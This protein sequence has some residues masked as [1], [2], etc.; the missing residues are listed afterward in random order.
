MIIIVTGD[1]A[2]GKTTF[3]ADLTEKLQDMGFRV[4]GFYSRGIWKNRIRDHYNLF[5]IKHKEE[6]LLCDRNVSDEKDRVGEYYFRKETID[7]GIQ[8]IR[9]AIE[10][11]SPVIVLDEAGKLEI[12]GKGWFPVLK[13]VLS[14]GNTMVVVAVRK[15]F[16]DQIIASFSIKNPRIVNI[17]KETSDNV[18]KYISDILS[19]SG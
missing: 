17:S 13:R 8:I 6:F 3:I 16:V 4:E 10:T 14:L 2:E 1:K 18:V 9:N 11:S 7:R 5:D 19:A 12:T 15:I